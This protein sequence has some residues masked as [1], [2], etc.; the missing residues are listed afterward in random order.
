MKELICV[1]KIYYINVL[2]I[3]SFVF[4]FKE[5]NCILDTMHKFCNSFKKKKLF[6]KSV[7]IFYNKMLNSTGQRGIQYPACKPAATILNNKRSIVCRDNLRVV[8]FRKLHPAIISTSNSFLYHSYLFK[9]KLI[10]AGTMAEK[11]YIELHAH[12]RPGPN[13]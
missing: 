12:R 3:T 1:M 9:N 2:D 13:A 11:C 10:D 8:T 7:I 5:C 6:K 4:V